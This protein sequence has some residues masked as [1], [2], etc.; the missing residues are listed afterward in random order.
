MKL[1][2]ITPDFGVSRQRLASMLH[3]RGVRL[4]CRTPSGSE[5]NEM[6]H[7]YA[8][9]ESLERVGSRLGFSARPSETG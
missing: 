7:R 6:V 5:V 4:R 3:T 1:S 9:D 8:A 2:E